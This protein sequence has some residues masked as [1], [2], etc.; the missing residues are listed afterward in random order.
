MTSYYVT[1]GISESIPIQIFIF[2]LLTFSAKA[3]FKN[4]VIT[5]GGGGLGGRPKDDMWWHDDTPSFYWNSSQAHDFKHMSRAMLNLNIE[6]VAELKKYS[7]A[8][9]G[10]LFCRGSILLTIYAYKGG[11]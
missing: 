2:A 11:G 3:L 7:S 6:R 5:W 4:D 1:S 9:R 10:I 8:T